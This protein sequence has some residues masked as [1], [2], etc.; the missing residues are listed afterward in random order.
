MDPFRNIQSK[1]LS[2]VL[3]FARI[4]CFFSMLAF[5]VILLGTIFSPF[6]GFPILY[7]I[8]FIGIPISGFI[9]SALLAAL[10]AFEEGFRQ[11]TERIL[12]QNQD[13][14]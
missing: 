11:R 12:T 9:L 13:L 14:T 3:S 8:W 2:I 5:I 6:I 4:L 10:V 1:H 7:F